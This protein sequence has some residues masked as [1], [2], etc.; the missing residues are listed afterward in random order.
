MTN[1]IDFQTQVKQIM[2]SGLNA[3]GI[4][5]HTEERDVIER[6]LLQVFSDAKTLRFIKRT[7]LLSFEQFDDVSND[8][9]METEG[10]DDAREWAEYQELNY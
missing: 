5:R 2:A 10:M 1:K 9:D 7:E 4:E 8:M 6:L 3:R